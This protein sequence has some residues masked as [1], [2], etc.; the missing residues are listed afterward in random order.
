MHVRHYLHADL[1]ERRPA[2]G[3]VILDHP[4]L[5]GLAHDRPG[6]GDAEGFGD[7]GSIGIGRLGCDAI[8]HAVRKRDVGFD[9]RRQSFIL[10]TREGNKR[11]ARD[12]AVALQVVAGHDRERRQARGSPPREPGAHV[13]KDG[14]WRRR[15]FEI[16]ADGR[17]LR[18]ED[19]RFVVD[20]V[21]AFGDGQAD[22][23]G[24]RIG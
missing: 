19:A 13:A 24:G 23:A 3:E 8:H 4:L 5:E 17:I 15:V 20:V 2:V 18:V 16:R 1:F 10:Q 14:L 9:P 22:D 12:L 11:G 7:H 6:V 21:A